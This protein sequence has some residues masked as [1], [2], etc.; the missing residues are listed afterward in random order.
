MDIGAETQKPAA[1]WEWRTP[2]SMVLVQLF[3][4]GMILLSKLSISGGIFIF[5]L[6]AYRSLFGAAVILPL[7]LI[8]ERGKWKEMGWHATGWIFLNAFIGY[9]VPMSLYCY[10]L[11]DTTPSYAVI[12]VN[13]IPLATFILSLVFRME[14]LRIWSVVGSLK[15]TG[16]LFSVGGT[17]LISLY[18]GKALHLWDPILK[19]DPK[20][21]TTEGAGN[22]LRGTIFLV[23]SS[24]AYACWYLIQSKVLKV[25]PYKYWSSMVTCF[26]GGFQTALVGIILNT[27]KNAWKLGWNLDLVTILYSGA[28]ATA[29]K[30]CLNSWV[31]AK[32]GPTY[33]PMF[34]PLCVVFTILLDSIIIGN[35]I[36][37]GSL[38][39]TTMVLVGLYTF[40][41]AK[42][43]EVR[44]K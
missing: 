14:T 3:I 4:T 21:Q 17:M 28:L 12:F 25:Y 7:A 41:C 35:E 42:S 26:V 5:A 38:L 31:V 24:F 27:D 1:G 18:K 39:G 8:Y 22:Q 33:P 40:L 11:R 32:R 30:Y 10:G 9:A 6:L 36:T 29:G 23:G 37:V 44:D 13:L 34:N 19:I 20:E 15:I 43:K 2:A 16:V